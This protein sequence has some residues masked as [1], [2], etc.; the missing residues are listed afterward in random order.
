MD[1]VKIQILIPSVLVK[2]SDSALLASSQADDANAAGPGT[3][4]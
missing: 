1:L 3:T 4:L 2:A